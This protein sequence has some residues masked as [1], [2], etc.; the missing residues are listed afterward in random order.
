MRKVKI[1]GITGGSAS[2]KSLVAKK[3]DDAFKES[4]SVIIIRQDDY[5]KNLDHL[6]FEERLQINFDHPDAFDTELLINHLNLLK[7]KQPIEKPL[8]DFNQYTRRKEVEI[9]NPADVIIIEGLFILENPDLRKLCDIRIFIDTDSDIRFIRR[10]QRDLIAR[11][12]SVESVITQYVSTVKQM[13][14][15]F[16][17]PC[18][19]YADIIIPEGGENEIGINLLINQITSLI[20]GE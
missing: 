20:K 7:N 9:I 13:H 16:V 17:E 15:L 1:I 19:K 4:E 11:G 12:R 3:I 10:L 6:S 5:Y 8:Y 2:G 18:R 14:D